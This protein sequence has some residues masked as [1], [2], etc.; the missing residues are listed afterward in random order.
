MNSAHVLLLVAVRY[1]PISIY[2][3][4]YIVIVT[5]KNVCMIRLCITCLCQLIQ[6]IIS[7]YRNM[8]KLIYGYIRRNWDRAAKRRKK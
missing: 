7:H 6:N 5:N 4:Y 2:I 1:F 3:Y 8:L